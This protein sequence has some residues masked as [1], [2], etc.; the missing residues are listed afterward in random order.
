[1]EF[2]EPLCQ[3]SLSEDTGA[4]IRQ[5][6]LYTLKLIVSHMTSYNDTLMKVSC[7]DHTGLIYMYNCFCIGY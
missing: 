1:M 7:L 4:I 2:V 3:L 6:S 5:T